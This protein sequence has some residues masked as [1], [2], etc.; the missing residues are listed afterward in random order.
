MP[1]VAVNGISLHYQYHPCD[2][3]CTPEA[4]PVLLLAGM[5]SDSASWQPAV[6]PLRQRYSLLI[7]DNRCTGRT[8]MPAQLASSRE[9]MVTDVLCLLDELGIERVSIVGHSMGAMLGWTLA[10]TAP[11][12]VSCLVSAAGLPSILPARIALFR[13]LQALRSESNERDWFALL[14]QF[15]FCPTFFDNPATLQAAL[16]GSMN[17]PFK[18]SL[19]AFSQQ[20]D[21]LDSFLSPPP[22][23]RI[24]CPVTL[25]TGSHDALM[26]PRMLQAF[27]E[28]HPQIQ[29]AIVENAAHA[30]HWEQPEEFV[31]IV[32]NS[33][34]SE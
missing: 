31:R 23:E 28:V 19:A 34:E 5:A 30:L 21:A 6:A 32:L 9:A 10:C 7:P 22:L 18:Q 8:I 16:S 17:Y 26:T 33:L 3:T 27:A 1:Q 15:L 20:V 4:P 14:Y 11:E 2:Q 24:D 29:T 13:S 12:R 25:M